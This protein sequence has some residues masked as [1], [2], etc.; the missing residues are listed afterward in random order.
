MPMHL[1]QSTAAVVVEVLW[2]T[3]TPPLILL[4]VCKCV[5]FTKNGAFRVQLAAH[6]KVANFFF[7]LFLLL[8]PFL[9]VYSFL[10]NPP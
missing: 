2:C 10:I 9:V 7:L 8:F 6:A 4:F 5:C 1:E 3:P